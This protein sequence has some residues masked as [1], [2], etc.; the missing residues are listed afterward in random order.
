MLV[1]SRDSAAGSSIPSVANSSETT[2]EHEYHQTQ[3]GKDKYHIK[4]V[5]FNCSR[6]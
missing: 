3:Q 6:L 2:E 5:L 1:P 4:Y